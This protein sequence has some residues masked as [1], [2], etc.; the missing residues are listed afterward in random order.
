MSDRRLDPEAFREA[1]L[2]R[3][4]GVEPATAVPGF[5]RDARRTI[6]A[7]SCVVVLVG[8]AA[9]LSR[10]SEGPASDD[11]P[12]T[13]AASIEGAFQR[14]SVEPVGEGA[15]DGNHGESATEAPDGRYQEVVA[16][17]PGRST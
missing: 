6:W 14:L 16:V 4:D 2:S 10:W 8:V 12:A 15:S 1:V 3:L 11:A 7:V 9:L 17:A 5:D 13:A